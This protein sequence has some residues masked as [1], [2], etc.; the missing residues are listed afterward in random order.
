MNQCEL[1]EETGTWDGNLLLPGRQYKA[2]K[3]LCLLGIAR[4]MFDFYLLWLWIH[5]AID[6]G[7]RSLY[8]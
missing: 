2:W 8:S 6:L 3:S 1:T 4:P 5:S 7:R